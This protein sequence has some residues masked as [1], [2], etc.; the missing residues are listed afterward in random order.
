M[1]TKPNRRWR[2]VSAQVES[3][4]V[5]EKP[6]QNRQLLKDNYASMYQRPLWIFLPVKLECLLK[7]QRFVSQVGRD[8]IE[9][10]TVETDRVKLTIYIYY[11]KFF[12]YAI[13]VASVLLYASFQV[14]VLLRYS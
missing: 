2:L 14:L 7:E 13:S 6:K 9:E 8:L 1:S 11:A 5:Y 12:G 10:E 4:C 3:F